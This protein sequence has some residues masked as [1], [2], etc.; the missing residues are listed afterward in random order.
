MLYGAIV[1]LEWIIFHSSLI[2]V[3]YVTG[4]INSLPYVRRDGSGGAQDDE[5]H[6]GAEYYAVSLFVVVISWCTNSSILIA[7]DNYIYLRKIGEIRERRQ[8]A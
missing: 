8:R 4:I 6:L 3:Y 7:T 2:T 1:R 5:V